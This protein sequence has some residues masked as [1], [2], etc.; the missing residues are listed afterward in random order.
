MTTN[1]LRILS[2][3]WNWGGETSIDNIARE[4]GVSVEYARLLCQNLKQEN[5]IDFS[6]YKLA[7]IK[8]KGK[9]LITKKNS[10]SPKKIVVPRKTSRFGLGKDKKGRLLLNY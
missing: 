2:I 1:E 3:I 6:Y 5:C 10:Q 9:L 4:A 7:K 8:N